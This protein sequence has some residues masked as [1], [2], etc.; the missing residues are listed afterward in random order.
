MRRLPKP[1]L[2]GQPFAGAAQSRRPARRRPAQVTLRRSNSGYFPAA[3]IGLALCLGIV[4]ATWLMNE[5]SRGSQPHNQQAPGTD[6]VQP[7]RQKTPATSAA[8]GRWWDVGLAPK[9][10]IRIR[11]NLDEPGPGIDAA[12]ADIERHDPA[13]RRDKDAK[14]ETRKAVTEMV[15]LLKGVEARLEGHVAAHPGDRPLMQKVRDLMG[16][17]ASWIGMLGPHR[18]KEIAEFF[19]RARG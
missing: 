17:E 3:L 9:E 13:S 16:K 4:A 14:A 1:M 6:Q 10:P 7:A 11:V 15:N 2:T 8:A 19:A 18:D 5:G 12:I